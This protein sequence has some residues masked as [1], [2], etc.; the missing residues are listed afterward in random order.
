MLLVVVNV[1]VTFVLVTLR[2]H[3]IARWRSQS[4]LL[5]HLPLLGVESRT[6]FLFPLLCVQLVLVGLGFPVSI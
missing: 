5:L 2:G 4:R 6:A 1:N 3:V